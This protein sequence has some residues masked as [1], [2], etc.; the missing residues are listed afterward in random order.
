[1]RQSLQP[2]ASGPWFRS[3]PRAAPPWPAARR[4]DWSRRRNPPSQANRRTIIAEE[5][6]PRLLKVDGEE[7]TFARNERERII[8]HVP[9]DCTRN[10]G[11]VAEAADYAFGFNPPYEICKKNMCSH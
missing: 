5:C 10:V 9:Q 11:V 6:L 4:T 2:D 8:R 1:M 7:P 3:P